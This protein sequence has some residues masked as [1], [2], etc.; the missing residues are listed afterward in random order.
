MPECYITQELTHEHQQFST[1]HQKGM[2]SDLE[3][4]LVSLDVQID[5]LMKRRRQVHIA[6]EDAFDHQLLYGPK[7]D[8]ATDR[9][10]LRALMTQVSRCISDVPTTVLTTWMESILPGAQ[11]WS[12][13]DGDLLIPV[14]SSYVQRG[15]DI[16]QFA[17]S[18]EELISTFSATYGIGY[19]SVS[20]PSGRYTELTRHSDGRWTRGIDGE[21][22]DDLAAFL[23]QEA[24]R[25]SERDDDESY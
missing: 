23:S 4:E 20:M 5:Y 17:H 13:R 6:L 10:A 11:C 25:E 19:L 14:V 22:V 9:E 8:Y 3:L 21:N 12:F 1:S 7:V 2:P 15:S 18:A 24:A 16:A